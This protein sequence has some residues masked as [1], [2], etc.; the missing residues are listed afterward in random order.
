MLEEFGLPVLKTII[1]QRQVVAD[2]YT[3]ELTV[4]EMKGRPA[5]ES[6][7]EFDALFEEAIATM[8]RKKMTEKKDELTGAEAAS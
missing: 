4:F 3:Q 5:A 6:A 7:R 1:H 2:T 8:T